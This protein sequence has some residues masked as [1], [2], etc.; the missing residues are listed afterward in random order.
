MNSVVMKVVILLSGLV[1]ILFILQFITFFSFQQKTEMSEKPSLL[2]ES[3]KRMSSQLESLLEKIEISSSEMKKKLDVLEKLLS[4]TA[5]Q[6]SLGSEEA[7]RWT[8]YL[9]DTLAKKEVP[10]L[11]TP[12]STTFNFN[13][14][15]ESIEHYLQR[16]HRR[17]N[18][19]NTR[20]N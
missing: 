16:F 3:Q 18:V 9:I 11:G 15:K 4:Q 7:L 5:Y 20:R 12:F 19:Q 13:R 10:S 8:G 1:V 2:E 17:W 14:K 6:E